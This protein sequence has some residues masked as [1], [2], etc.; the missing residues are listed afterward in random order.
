MNVSIF[1]ESGAVSCLV[2]AFLLLAGLSAVDFKVRLLPNQMVLM[3][4][5]L[6]VCFHIMTGF[7]FLSPL[8]VFMG[9]VLGFGAFYAIRHV[10]SAFYGQEAMGF[11]DVKLIGAGGLWLGPEGIVLGVT[12]GAC[13]GLVHGSILGVCTALKT[14]TKPDFRRLTIPAGPG[15]AFGIGAVALWRFWDVFSGL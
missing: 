15:F 6:G 12:I 7:V 9:G 3:T 8:S 2:G 5:F 14:G 10:S 4:A 13:A 11:G 1:S